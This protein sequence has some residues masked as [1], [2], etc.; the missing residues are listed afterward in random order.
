MRGVPVSVRG[1]ARELP[2]ARTQ[3]ETTLLK[4]MRRHVPLKVR[5]NVGSST[6]HVEHGG[7]RAVWQQRSRGGRLVATAVAVLVLLEGIGHAADPAPLATPVRLEW[8]LVTD[9]AVRGTLELPCMS[10]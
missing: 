9:R 10:M 8:W 6:S 3:G 7:A 4:L 1:A 5:P 2:P